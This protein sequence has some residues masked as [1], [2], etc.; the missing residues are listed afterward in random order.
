VFLGP[1]WQEAAVIFRLLAPTILAFAFTNPFAWLMLAS[2]RAGR[3][4]RIAMAVTPVLILG[5]ALGLGFG[6]HGV[7]VGFSTTMAVCVVPVLVWAKRGTLISLP[8]LIRSARPALVSIAL[9]IAATLLVRPLT[10]WLE[11]GFERLVLE[12]SVLFGVYLFTLA[13]IMKQKSVYLGLL[14]DIGL[15]PASGWREA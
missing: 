7:A 3:N 9:G 12:C 4:V 1:N 2:G 5:Y 6:P 8:D 10:D 11:P 14:R 13:F 15:F